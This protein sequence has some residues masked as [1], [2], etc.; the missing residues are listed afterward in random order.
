MAHKILLIDDEKVIVQVVKDVLEEN[1]YEVAV[2][3][4]G[5]EGFDKAKTEDP[6]LIVLDIHMP[7]MNGY[8]FMRALRA[9]KV[10]EGRPMTPVIMLTVNPTMKD[11]FRLEGVKGYFVKPVK[12]D[13]LVQKIKECLGSDG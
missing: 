11:L 6:D 8:E 10:I 3:Y 2:A 9:Q 4:D 13:V 1:H 7:A 5:R 12:M